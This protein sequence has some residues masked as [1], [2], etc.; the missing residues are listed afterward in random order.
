M[1]KKLIGLALVTIL[2]VGAVGVVGAAG[3]PGRPGWAGACGAGTGLGLGLGRLAGYLGLTADQQQQLLKLRQDFIARTQDLRFQIQQ[4][5]L[6]LRQLWSQTP[7]NEQKISAKTAE[8]TSLRVRLANEAKA[9]SDAMKNVLTPE[10]QKKLDEARAQA[11]QQ[12]WGPGGRA[13][14]GG[15]GGRGGMCGFGR[16]GG[17]GGLGTVTE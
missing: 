16:F 7:P 1:V 10:Q 17:F 6:E 11:Q 13:G 15:W 9:L 5:M 14:R 8:V 4:K 3:R 2:I 12:G